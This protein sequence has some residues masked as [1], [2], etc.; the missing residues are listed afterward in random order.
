MITPRTLRNE[1]S[2]GRFHPAYYFFGVDDY[3]MVEA[4]KYLIRNFIPDL[5]IITNSRKL[6]GR[7]VSCKDILTEL[8]TLPM[9]GEKQAVIISNIQ[10]FKPTEVDRILKMLSPADPNRMVIMTSP[11]AKAPKSKSAFVKKMDSSVQVVEFKRLAEADIRRTIQ[12]RLKKAEIGIEPSALNLMAE[13]IDGNLGP[14]ESEV[15]KLINYKQPGE[16]VTE[17]DIATVC[18]GYARY[19]IFALAD[20]IIAGRTGK[21]L[22]MIDKLLSDG[23]PPFVIAS[24][25]Q[26]NFISLYLVKNGKKPLGNRNFLVPKFRQQASRYDNKRLEQNIIE[27]ADTDAEFRK[28][29]IRPEAALEILALKLIGGIS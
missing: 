25:L 12:T 19:D 5:Q 17:A 29:A 2:S 3:R 18:S 27:I 13:L 23:D 9:L 21:V 8:Q 10:S 24:L 20:E 14:L 22:R 16:T 15:N 28:Q 6:D 26:G 4:E 1:V 11:A 7:K